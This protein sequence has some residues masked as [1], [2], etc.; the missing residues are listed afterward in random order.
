ML[1]IGLKGLLEVPMFN[2]VQPL[3]L[4][5]VGRVEGETSLSRCLG[6]L[7]FF[8]EIGGQALHFLKVGR[9]L[10]NWVNNPREEMIGIF[11]F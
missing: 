5:C 1:L 8:A 6:L 2:A 4:I 10:A 7:P 3:L 11:I 9:L